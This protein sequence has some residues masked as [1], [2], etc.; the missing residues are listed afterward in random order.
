MG[1]EFD[2]YYEWLGIPPK[3]Q[4]ANHYRLLGID[5]NEADAEVIRHAAKQRLA[6]L[7]TLQTGPRGKAANQLLNE[8]SRAQ[9]TLLDPAQRQ[10]Y[11]ATLQSPSQ[12]APP[13]PPPRPNGSPARRLTD[14]ERP[15]DSREQERKSSRRRGR[16]PTTR[17][18]GRRPVD[19][20]QEEFTEADGASGRGI[21]RMRI[22][23]FVPVGLAVILLVLALRSKPL[24]VRVYIDKNK[25][26]SFC[27]YN[28]SLP[29]LKQFAQ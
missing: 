8:I 28:S 17:R 23:A 24:I 20:E 2:P 12:A 13:E 15:N 6:Y 14:R 26:G 16:T 19:P 27:S 10:A 4:P 25:N 9:H 18:R 22:L 5:G 7:R 3:H 1:N 21:K 11:D 29:V